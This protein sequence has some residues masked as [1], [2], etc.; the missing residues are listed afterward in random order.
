MAASRFATASVA[1]PPMPK[2]LA[3]NL[4]LACSPKA[5]PNCLRPPGPRMADRPLHGVGV[6]VTRPRTQATEL[7]DAIEAQGGTAYCLPVIDIAPLDELDVRA[8]AK[9][10]DKPDFVIFVSRNAVE[11]GIEYAANGKV[12]AI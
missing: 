2:R 11:Y 9:A 4:P 1:K 7:V 12:A 8:A 3:N 6:L 10:L 5:Q